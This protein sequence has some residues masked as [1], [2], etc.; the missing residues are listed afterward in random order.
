[1]ILFF[2][3]FFD[4]CFVVDQGHH[5]LPVLCRG[6]LSYHHKVPFH[7]AIFLHGISIYLEHEVIS[8]PYHGW[9]DLDGV[10]IFHRLNG[11]SGRHLPQKR[12]LESP[13]FHWADH[14]NG[15]LTVFFLR[16]ANITF[17]FQDLEIGGNRVIRA[18]FELGADLV[19]TGRSSPFL[20]V[21]INIR[22]KSL[23][24]VC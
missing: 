11:F 6:L 5:R 13:G 12:K 1:M 4:G 17:P 7:D 10:Y 21:A 16:K 2:V 19:K 3:I 8:G 22:Q 23:L 18:K 15:S 24:F 14:L 9:R 20:N